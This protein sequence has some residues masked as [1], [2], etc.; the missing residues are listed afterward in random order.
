MEERSGVD[1]VHRKRKA[2]RGEGRHPCHYPFELRLKAVKLYLEEGYSQVWISEQLGFGKKTLVDWVKR[3]RELGEEGLRSRYSGSRSAKIPP[4]VRHKITE[5]KR[6]YPTFGVKRIAQLLRRVFFL[7]ASRETVRRTLHQQNL[8]LKKRKAKRS[9]PKPRFFERATPNQMWQSDIFTFRLGGKNAYLIGFMDDYSR[10][11]VGCDLFRSQSAEHVLEVYRAAVG[12]YGVPKEVL[13]DQGRQYTNWRGKTRFELELQKDRVNHIKSRAHHPMTLGKIERFWKTIWEDFLVR[14][15]FE[16][17]DSAR[18]RVRLWVKHYNHQRPHQ[19]IGGLCPA[20]RF[21]EIQKELR[22]V[23]E[24]GIK[25]NLEEL[26]LRGETKEPFYMVGRMGNESVVIRAEKGKLRLDIDREKDGR[27]PDMVYD[28]EGGRDESYG[29]QGQKANDPL[30]R[31]AEVPGGIVG[32]EREEKGLSGMQ[33][34][35]DPRDAF[36]PLAGASDGSDAAGLGAEDKQWGATTGFRAEAAEASDAQGAQARGQ[37]SQAR[38]EVG[39]DSATVEA[40]RETELGEGRVHDETGRGPG[41]PEG[42]ADSG[43]TQWSDQCP[44]GGQEIG[45]IAQDLL[46]VGEKGVTGDGGSFGQSSE[47]EAGATDRP[48][49]G[50]VKEEERSVGEKTQGVGTDP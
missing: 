2:A 27:D 24:R 19:G 30:Q 18:E 17:F 34:I 5:L 42:R 44:R 31:R 7:S 50:G 33:G 35:G 16:S 3:Y 39:E 46:Q 13:T 23:I 38:P 15:Q 6:R 29:E 45:G 37:A 1:R 14:A 32:M 22:E 28:R 8:I 48:G 41:A 9:P 26:A 40:G 11:L 12:E 36:H 20:D 47:R 25:D 10:Y 49:E 21:F 43:G 4:A